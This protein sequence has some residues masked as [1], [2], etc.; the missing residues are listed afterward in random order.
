MGLGGL[1][2][3]GLVWW[4]SRQRQV[5]ARALS[6]QQTTLLGQQRQQQAY[7]EAI[8]NG[9]QNG[10]LSCSPVYSSDNQLVDLRIEMANLAA[11]L[12]NGRTVDQLIG[13]TLLTAFPALAGSPLMAA[14]LT[15]ARSGQPQRLEAFY[16]DA[17]LK[18]W[19][20][21]IVSPLPQG[22]ILISFL[23]CTDRHQ[24]ETAHLHQ[25]NLLQRISESGHIGIMTH[26]PIRDPSGHIQDFRYAYVNEQAQLWLAVDLRQV[27]TH[28]LRTLTFGEDG[29]ET[30]RQMAKVV[31]TGESTQ[32]EIKLSDGRVMFMVISALGEGTVSTFMDV[33]PQRQ[34]QQRVRY[35]A[36]LEQQVVERTQALAKTLRALEES[37]EELQRALAYEKELSELKGRFVSMASHE[38]RTPLTAV[39]SSANLIE[40]Y[41]GAEQQDK[42]LKH[43]RRIRLAVKQLTSILEEFLSLDR[44]EAGQLTVQVVE[45][46]LSQLINE[47][48]SDLQDSLKAHQTIRPQLAGQGVLRQDESLLRKILINLLSNAIKYSGPGSVVSLQAE[49]GPDQFTLRVQDEGIGIS[50]A[51]QVHLFERFYRASNALNIGGTGLGL[52]I[53]RRYVELLGGQ[54]RLHSELNK[55]TLMTVV[56]PIQGTDG[57]EIPMGP[58][59]R[60]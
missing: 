51:D 1:T 54:L 31:Q 39:L 27:V 45:I 10:L 49:W 9:S 32:L 34:A 25:A 42:R 53:V 35:Q 26:Q 2:G 13:T 14:Y 22:H 24:A 40:K 16:Q 38:F 44:L 17:T 36:E 19:Y 20:E 8:L 41:P 50:E 33:T 4:Q 15:T 30:I 5:Q 46:E 12:I 58:D 6:N 59:E 48:V 23:D 21:V 7:V 18:G 43:I 3:W 29:E 11:S 60:D 47:V 56:L 52:H 55:G 37:R 28:S 57:A